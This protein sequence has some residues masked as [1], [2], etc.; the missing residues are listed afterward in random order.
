MAR[1]RATRGFSSALTW[2]KLRVS[3]GVTATTLNT[4][5]PSPEETGPVTAFGIA[6]K[7]DVARGGVRG[8]PPGPCRRAPRRRA[9]GGGGGLLHG[10][11]IRAGDPGG[12]H[13]A[14]GGLGRRHDHLDGALFRLFELVLVLLIVGM[15][16]VV[17]DLDV[18]GD[19]LRRQD[20][21]LDPAQLGGRRRRSCC[22]RIGVRAAPGWGAGGWA[23]AAK[24]RL[25]ISAVRVS[26]WNS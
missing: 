2:S 26:P 14:G 1:S 11:P 12:R 9:L 24:G 20:D 18:G 22:R 3:P 8:M 10:G 4:C 21:G 7:T 13:G 5:Q 17:A 25:T 19:R 15:E 16:I 23:A 6:A